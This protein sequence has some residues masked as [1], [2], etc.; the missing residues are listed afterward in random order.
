MRWMLN[1]LTIETLT[2]ADDQ[3]TFNQD[4]NE[5]AL[6]NF[7][8]VLT[9]IKSTDA[10]ADLD[11]TKQYTS[12]W[13]L[14]V[15]SLLHHSEEWYK[16]VYFETCLLRMLNSFEPKSRRYVVHQIITRHEEG[17]FDS[18]EMATSVSIFN[19]LVTNLYLS[20]DQS[21]PRPNHFSDSNSQSL[22]KFD[23]LSTRPLNL[24]YDFVEEVEYGTLFQYT[25][26]AKRFPFFFKLLKYFKTLTASP[27]Q[28]ERDEA[29]KLL[30]HMYEIFIHLRVNNSQFSQH[31]WVYFVDKFLLSG[32]QDSPQA[33]M[34]GIIVILTKM[35]MEKSLTYY[36]QSHKEGTYDW[37][38]LLSKD[39]DFLIDYRRV[40][41]QYMPV[42]KRQPNRSLI[43]PAINQL[44]PK[45]LEFLNREKTNEEW[46]KLIGSKRVVKLSEV[47]PS[48]ESDDEEVF[49]VIIH[50]KVPRGE[51]GRVQSNKQ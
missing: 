43:V 33:S 4:Q 37:V 18:P 15:L 46:A 51:I 10:F 1:H 8:E 34:T 31:Y 20:N 48:F 13:F 45:E 23:F 5:T 40:S 9:E 22:F 14:G 11:F 38:Q 3:M 26:C 35:V 47:D 6:K 28:S 42:P 25:A 27:D 21:A 50:R 7:E 32:Y 24:F 41:Q 30:L 44:R 2:I 17:D 19:N 49:V 39:D 36:S 29:G 16:S 12:D